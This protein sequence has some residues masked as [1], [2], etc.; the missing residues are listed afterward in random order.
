M[1]NTCLVEANSI[2]GTKEHFVLYSGWS[3]RI[4]LEQEAD[5]DSIRLRL[6]WESYGF[7]SLFVSTI[8]RP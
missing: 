4:R 8:D 7:D 2:L 3:E 1:Q 6:P 5:K